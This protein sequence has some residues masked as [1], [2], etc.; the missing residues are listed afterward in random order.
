MVF[1]AEDALFS[2]LLLPPSSWTHF[3]A[4]TNLN[5]T[6]R[7]LQICDGCVCVCVQVCVMDLQAREREKERDP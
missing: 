6:R 5:K 4:E 7:L 2:T 1:E 3:P